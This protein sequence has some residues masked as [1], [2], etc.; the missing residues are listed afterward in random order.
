[1]IQVTEGLAF[2]LGLGI[3][4]DLKCVVQGAL[5]GIVRCVLYVF[6]A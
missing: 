2:A 6:M 5:Y 3:D 4:L 1:M